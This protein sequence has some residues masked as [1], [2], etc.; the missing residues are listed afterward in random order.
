[1]NKKILIIGG[2]VLL[3]GGIA[4]LYFT[5]KKKTEALLSGG[6]SATQPSTTTPITQPSLSTPPISEVN[7]ELNPIKV[8]YGQVEINLEKAQDIV[9]KML[10]GKKWSDVKL[11]TLKNINAKLSKLGYQYNEGILTKI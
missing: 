2:G 3:L 4:Y 5:N 1:M 11:S 9:R 7:S 6:A 8:N 10:K